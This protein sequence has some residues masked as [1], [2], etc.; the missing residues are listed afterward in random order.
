LGF[1]KTRELCFTGNLIPAQELYN[2]GYVAQVVSK[3]KIEDYVDTM[4][5][6]MANLPSATLA[7]NKRS[8]NNYLD[9]IGKRTQEDYAEALRALCGSYTGGDEHEYGSRAWAKATN[10]KGLSYHLRERD[11]PFA[12]ADRWWRERVAA[13]PKYETGTKEK[14][15]DQR[16]DV[17]AARKKAEE[18]KK[19]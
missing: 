18:L 9:A 4:A 2:A 6:A 3:E 16:P 14:G 1:A 12:E 19:K 15:W 5:Q 10:A 11:G 17:I 13:R 7:V 8:I